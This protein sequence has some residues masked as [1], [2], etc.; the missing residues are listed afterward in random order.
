MKQVTE[1]YNYNLTIQRH[2]DG[3]SW[4]VT[5]AYR[6]PLEGEGQLEIKVDPML[7][8]ALTEYLCLHDDA[9][10][11]SPSQSFPTLQSL[12]EALQDDEVLGGY[13]CDSSESGKEVAQVS[14]I[15]TAER[16]FEYREIDIDLKWSLWSEDPESFRERAGEE[17]LQAMRQAFD[18]TGEPL[19]LRT[20]PAKEIRFGSVEIE[21]GCMR[22]EFRTEWDE[23]GALADTL[24]QQWGHD[25]AWTLTEDEYNTLH[26]TMSGLIRDWT[27]DLFEGF[28][29][30]V[31]TDDPI[32]AY[33]AGEVTRRSFEHSLGLVDVA[34]E[35]LLE[36]DEA[37]FNALK[38]YTKAFL[39]DWKGKAN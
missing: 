1:T 5:R 6:K 38:Q 8:P 12:I 35:Q 31:I 10:I 13:G 22:Y 29:C 2:T 24:I 20:A 4:Q 7:E 3:A 9:L 33:R 30:W 34:E 17:L 36:Q 16:P 11:G 18:G 27:Q 26:T 39:D 37:N 19:R 25:N 32:G 21:K 28:E 23:V 15:L 14:L